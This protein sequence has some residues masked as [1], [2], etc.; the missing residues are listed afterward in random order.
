MKTKFNIED[1]VWTWRGD[2]NRLDTKKTLE[3]HFRKIIIGGIYIDFE[4]LGNLNINYGIL[5]AMNGL[6]EDENPINEDFIFKTMEDALKANKNS[7]CC[8]ALN[9]IE[10][11]REYYENAQKIITQYEKEQQNIQP[12]KEQKGS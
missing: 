2:A 8:Q 5:N 9:T 12:A 11:H 4:R 7:F 10:Y 3:S 6:I 1:E